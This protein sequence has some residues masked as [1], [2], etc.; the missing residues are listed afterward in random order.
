MAQKRTF[1]SIDF[2]AANLKVAEFDVSERGV[3]RLLRYGLYPLGRAGLQ[4]ATRKGALNRGLQELFSSNFPFKAKFANCTLPGFQVFHKFL[5]LPA[6][7]L[8]KVSQIIQFEAQQN[9]PFPLD[10]VVW[11]YQILGALPSGELDVLLVAAKKNYIEEIFSAGGV[12]GLK[13]ELVDAPIAALAN[14]FRYNYPDLE[15]CSMLID[16][17]AKTSTVMFFDGDRFFCRSINIGASNIT[18]DFANESKLPFHEAEKIKISEGFV[19]LGGAYEEPENPYQAAISKIAR[20]V[21]TRLHIQITQ[22]IQFFR[23]QQGGRPPVRIFLS[24]GGSAMAYTVQFFQEKLN[25][26]VEYFNP[27]RNVEIDPSVDVEELAKVAH[28]MGEVVGLSL[29]TLARCP[30][31][32]NLLPV[33]IK[34]QQQFSQKKPYLVISFVGLVLTIIL[35]GVF[36]QK[37]ADARTLAYQ[38]RQPAL[39]M[40]Q[41][42][43]RIFKAA[44]NARDE[45]KRQLDQYIEWIEERFYWG[46]IINELGNIL[47]RTEA[48]LRRPGMRPNVWIESLIPKGMEPP[49]VETLGPTRDAHGAPPPIDPELARRYGL[50]PAE[51]NPAIDTHGMSPEEM[52]LYGLTPQAAEGADTNTVSEITL[53]CRAI[54]WDPVYEAADSQLAILL[55]QELQQSR[56][57]SPTNGAELVGEMQKDPTTRTF[58]FQ[59]KIRLARPIKLQ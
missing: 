35:L 8:S 20:Q 52:A 12:V 31:E 37:V 51:A 13:F 15:D 48:K 43:E 18:Q 50:L 55:L 23:T 38:Q 14:A 5:K 42:R 21:M 16:I 6:V 41:Q 57:L 47:A 9:I 44:L 26:P 45:A 3:I 32:L 28:C 2:G 11:D 53:T 58:S 24:G 39:E 29:R 56:Y 1:L 59:V 7:D 10:Q 54:S 22:T 36:F 27:F 49:K 33:E 46:D 17:G 34:R 19:G 40:L 4:D 30:I 25:L